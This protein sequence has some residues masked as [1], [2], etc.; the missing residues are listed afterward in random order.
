MKNTKYTSIAL[1]LLFGLMLGSCDKNLDIDPTQ[2]LES[3][4]FTDEARIQRSVGSAYAGLANIYGPKMNWASCHPPML[5]PGDDLVANGTG[6]EFFTFSGLTS[7]NGSIDEYWKRLY[8]IVGRCNFVLDRLD[9]PEVQAVYITP[10][11]MEANRGEA[12]FLRSWCY[13]RLWDWWRKAPIQ[14]ER[15]STLQD[16]Y[17]PPSE[18]FEMLDNAIASLEEAAGLLPDSWDARN[19]GRVTKN[20]AY[21]LL[22]RLY[23]LRAC[24]NNANT[25]DYQKALEAFNKISGSS[26][27]VVPFGDNFDYR[28]ENNIESLF[29]YQASH[30]PFRDNP[31]LDNDF[32]GDVGQMGAHWHM[33]TNHWSN[34][35]T[36]SMGPSPKLRNAFEPGD[37]RKSETF[38]DTADLDI[39]NSHVVKW[40]RFD[41]HAF[42]KYVNGER[43]NAFDPQWNITNLNNPRLLRLADVKLLAAE[44]YLA[45]GNAGEALR[46]VNDIRQRAREST[47]DGSV[48]PVPADLASVT[49][50]DIMHERFLEMA[51]EDGHR[52]TDLRRWH[53]AGY[54]NLATWNA[55]DFGFPFDPNLFAFD[56]S[57]HLLFPIPQS[58]MD[59]NPE[60]LA[61]GNNPGY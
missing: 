8:I 33:F 36:Q 30:A 3:I 6:N 52:W 20:S 26:A 59:R 57:T 38:R 34:Y 17:L 40:D 13:S 19:L 1:L 35:K 60:M 2:E 42:V 9:D 49:M 61:S 39:V 4:F 47:P 31:W 32:G 56:A 51:G 43:G 46:Q 21:G 18:G 24:Y 54:I 25:G 37:P 10:G 23:V 27:L 15:I 29:E 14:E 12:L 41:G 50:E 48:S 7:T 11:L 45:T 58:E 5:L 53:A 55:E 16:A 28:T 22:V 44:A